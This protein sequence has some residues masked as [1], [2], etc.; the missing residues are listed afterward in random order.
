MTNN[1]VTTWYAASININCHWYSLECTQSWWWKPVWYI[2]L[3]RGSIYI[4]T[5]ACR[6]NWHY[7]RMASLCWRLQVCCYLLQWNIN[8]IEKKNV[9]TKK[10][11]I[12]L[13]KS[14]ILSIRTKFKVCQVTLTHIRFLKLF[15]LRSKSPF[16]I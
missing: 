14:S 8:Q 2:G 4:L 6:L 15:I 7:Y 5:F 16:S 10:E 1:S 9:T 3:K 13:S 12:H 11:V